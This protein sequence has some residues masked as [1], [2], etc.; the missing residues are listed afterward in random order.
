MNLVILKGNI[1]RDVELRYTP[2]GTAIADFSIAVNRVWRDSDGDKK[3][4]VSFINCVAFGNQAENIGQ[5]FNKGSEILI[6]GRLKQ[7]SWEDKESGD[8]RSAIKVIVEAFHF[9]RGGNGDKDNDRGK[10][11]KRRR[12]D[13]SGRRSKIDDSDVPDRER[14]KSGSKR[15][16]REDRM[17]DDDDDVPFMTWL[18]EAFNYCRALVGRLSYGF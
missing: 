17:K 15:R 14:V 3:E 2:K 18:G 13:D 4:E 6:E 10:G 8:K 7:E 5:Y 16:N 1:T 9:T 11:S 12:D